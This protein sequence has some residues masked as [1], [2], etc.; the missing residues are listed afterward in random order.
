[1]L[2][3][4]NKKILSWVS[5]FI[6]FVLIFWFVA[7]FIDSVIY[8]AKVKKIEVV[9]ASK[10]IEDYIIS[11]LKFVEGANLSNLDIYEIKRYIETI[12]WITRASVRRKYPSVLKIKLLEFNPFFVWQM[13][14]RNYIV[15]GKNRILPK[16]YLS[17]MENVITIKD[18]KE[19]LLHSSKIRFLIYQD[20]R[21]LKLVKYLEYKD[22]RWNIVLSN[23]VV[24]K[25]PEK[26]EQEAWNLLL[27]YNRNKDILSRKIEYI[28]L[29]IKDT[30]VIEPL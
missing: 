9:N 28:D 19:A 17:K 16:S 6:G 4:N 15:D 26:G 25:M 18:G 11:Q 2:S 1:M 13:G 30:L 12:P 7:I 21:V 22:Y 29:R 20:L 24:I 5:I 3:L 14:D 23:G 8:Q 10:S 27:Q